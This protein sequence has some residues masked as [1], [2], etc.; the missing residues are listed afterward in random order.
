[1]IDTNDISD[2]N[3][4]NEIKD[5]LDTDKYIEII[6]NSSFD[7]NPKVCTYIEESTSQNIISQTTVKTI[8]VYKDS[9]NDRRNAL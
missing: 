8:T 9:S 6:R 1:M 7:F 5:K 3:I 2:S 4:I